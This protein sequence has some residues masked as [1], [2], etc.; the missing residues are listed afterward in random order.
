MYDYRIAA[1]SKAVK[2]LKQGVRDS[3]LS[4]L[5]EGMRS[6][7]SFLGAYAGATPDEVELIATG[8]MKTKNSS[9]PFEPIRIDAEPDGKGG[10]H[11]EVS[12]R[13]RLQAA[14]EAG[15]KN[16]VVDV[17]EPSGKVYKNV[18]IPVPR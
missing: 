2:A 18:V 10:L 4:Y 9:R 13:H 12:G 7:E 6:L 16:I 11:F 17:H 1:D 15:A 3:Q 5:R 14:R 8:K